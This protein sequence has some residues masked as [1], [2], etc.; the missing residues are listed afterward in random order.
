MGGSRGQAVTLLLTAALVV[1]VGGLVWAEARQD[2]ARR[3]WKV[4]A[5]A[6]F[7]LI[8]VDGYESFT[9][10]PWIMAGLVLSAIGDVA[11]IG[12]ARGPF[13]AGL[14]AFLLAHLAYAGGFLVAG[15]DWLASGLV[16]A[17]LAILF[18][19]VARWL[20]PHTG[21]LRGPV[22]SYML[23]ISAMVALAAG[24]AI[25]GAPT[26]TFPAA[27]LFYVSDLAVAR[28]RFVNPGADNRVWG[29]PVYY[30]AQYLFA[31]LV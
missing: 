20:L 5:S 4:A 19:V 30:L 7:L 10:S 26:A 3:V 12:R 21:D 13:L 2:P 18:W 29:L 8:A 1:A 22:V 27:A 14:S 6:S 11:L 23:V 25:E 16:A 17:G 31:S 24:V 28:D 15:P 9:W